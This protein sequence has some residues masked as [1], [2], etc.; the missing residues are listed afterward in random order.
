MARKSFLKR[1][2]LPLQSDPVLAFLSPETAATED[3]QPE[4]PAVTQPPRESPD[5]PG[6]T[7]EAET[8]EPA[9]RKKAPPA[10]TIPQAPKGY[11]L[12]PMFLETKTRKIQLSFRPSVYERVKAASVAAGLSFNEYCHR[13]L[14]HAVT[15][16]EDEPM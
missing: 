9:P 8:A 15:E 10:A 6:P 7:A 4:P 2:N 13:V 14:E 12:N 16:D 1:D 11:K 3:R 5:R